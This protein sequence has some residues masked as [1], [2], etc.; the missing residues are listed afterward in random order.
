VGNFKRSDDP[1]SL[2]GATAWRASSGWGAFR[3]SNRRVQRIACQTG[4]VR[5]RALVGGPAHPRPAQARCTRSRRWF[6]R[7]PLQ[8]RRRFVIFNTPPTHSQAGRLVSAQARFIA[9]QQDTMSA[10]SWEQS[11]RSISSGWA[12]VASGV[13]R[14]DRARRAPGS[15]AYRLIIAGKGLGRRSGPVLVERVEALAREFKNEQASNRWAACKTID[16]FTDFSAVQSKRAGIMGAACPRL[17]LI[18]AISGERMSTNDLPNQGIGGARWTAGGASKE[19]DG[20]RVRGMAI[21]RGS[22]SVG[23]FRPGEETADREACQK[24]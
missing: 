5:I 16:G 10:W 14:R 11:R 2:F 21:Q 22:T 1:Q 20:R 24:G 6:E 3:T 17:Q 18:R 9:A 23:R 4:Q 19:P 13:G 12:L 7:R 8:S 15:D